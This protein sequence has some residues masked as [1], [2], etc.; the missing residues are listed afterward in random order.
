[1][2]VDQVCDTVV[3]SA[4]VK[5]QWDRSRLARTLRSAARLLTVLAARHTSHP[6]QY[7]HRVGHHLGIWQPVHLRRGR[8]GVFHEHAA[9]WCLPVA[10]WPRWMR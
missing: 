9:G 8:D 4:V 2:T 1:M 7:R 10:L 5:T 6:W 3:Q